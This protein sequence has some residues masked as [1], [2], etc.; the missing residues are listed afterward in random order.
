VSLG[1]SDHGTRNLF[2]VSLKCL[3]TNKKVEKILGV[4]NFDKDSIKV[5]KI[6]GELV[7]TAKVYRSVNWTKYYDEMEKVEN[8]KS[9]CDLDTY[10]NF[11]LELMCK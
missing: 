7:F 9:E 8:A 10:E 2:E 4:C 3:K 5:K 11:E 1:P 6:N